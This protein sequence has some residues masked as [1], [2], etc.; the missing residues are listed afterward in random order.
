MGQ[1]SLDRSERTEED[2]SQGNDD[3]IK[4]QEKQGDEAQTQP[5]AGAQDPSAFS[6]DMGHPSCLWLEDP[7]L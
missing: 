3:K 1:K 4:D 7:H 6:L 5:C 2:E